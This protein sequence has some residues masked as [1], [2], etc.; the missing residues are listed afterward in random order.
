M[1]TWQNL[2]H[3]NISIGT[4]FLPLTL[5]AAIR[6]R[7]AAGLARRSATQIRRVPGRRQA[8][9]LGLVLVPVC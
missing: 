3:L 8:I 2:Y 1:V 9:V 7:R 6:L 4:I 5:E